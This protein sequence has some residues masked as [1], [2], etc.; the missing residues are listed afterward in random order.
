[1]LD[2]SMLASMR[3]DA[4]LMLPD[5]GYILAS[6]TIPDGQGGGTV[7]WGTAGTTPYRLDPLRGAERVEGAAL[8]PYH[9]YTLTLPYD[10][11]ITTLNR[12]QD[13][14]GQVY[15]VVAVDTGKSWAATK[16]A[17]VQRV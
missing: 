13:A 16:R 9:G 14:S 8:Q 4:A 3:D 17:E 2:D 10:A 5:T 7:T 12:F 11:T 15:S 6:T 1:M